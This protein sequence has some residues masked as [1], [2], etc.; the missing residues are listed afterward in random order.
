MLNF[1]HYDL[2][3][4]KILK[5]LQVGNKKNTVTIKTSA[6]NE[7]T[8]KQPKKNNRERESNVP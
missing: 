5:G 3:H 7:T 1:T 6:C 4:P 2:M 8:R